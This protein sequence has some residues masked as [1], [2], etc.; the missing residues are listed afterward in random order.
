MNCCVEC[1]KDYYIQNIITVRG[2][3][4]DCDFCSAKN[5][6]IYDIEKDG[7][8]L[9]DLMINI[10][11]L[12]TVSDDEGS[13]LLKIS[14]RDDWNIFNLGSES[15]NALIQKI[16]AEFVKDNNEV[17]VEKLI[18]P[19]LSDIDF[20]KESG[21]VRGHSWKEFADSIKTENRFHNKMFNPDVFASFVSVISRTVDAKEIFYRA[22][23]S[24]NSIGYTINDMGTPLKGKASSGRINPEGIS[25]LYVAS[26]AKTVLNEVR[27][28][29]YDYVT[30]GEF[31]L[32]RN[33]KVVNLSA[34]S[35]TSPF[36]YV[37]DIEKY[38]VNKTIFEEMALDFSK[39]L[40]RADSVLEYLPTQY[41]AEFIKSQGYD[42]VQYNSTLKSEGYNIAIFD[43]NLLE[44]VDVKNVEVSK[45]SYET[46]PELE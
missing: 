8:D 1:F 44:C 20:L 3:K 22:R 41:I 21:V 7:T 24:Q 23:I 9:S 35:T 4:G 25:V 45:L 39:P 15:I 18:I 12:Y 33:L 43:S 16:C 10:L 26:D 42:G 40:R 2:S 19:A 36:E 17:F 11:Q 27:A 6:Y 30:I 38:V 29:T 32:K 31:I 28:T 13:K 5:T 34:I 14:L 46:Q 37:A